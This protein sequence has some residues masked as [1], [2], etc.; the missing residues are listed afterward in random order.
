MEAENVV[1]VLYSGCDRNLKSE[2]QCATCGHW[3]H[4][5]CGDMKGQMVDSGKWCCDRHTGDR[6]CQLEVKLQITLE[7]IENLK[8]K[9]KGLED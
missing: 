2:T 4:N 6:L 8:W 5:S 1:L 3:F 7:Q 9:N